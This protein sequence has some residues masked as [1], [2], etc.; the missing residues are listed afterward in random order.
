MFIGEY[1]HSIDNKSR[2]FIPSKFRSGVKK[3]I[4]TRGLE[5]CLFMYPVSSWKNITQKLK[6]LPLAKSEARAFSRILLSGAA[7][8]SIDRQ[9][10]ILVPQNLGSFANVKKNVVIIGVLDRI[11]IWSVENWNSYS[12][13]SIKSF[14]ELAE[15]LIDLGI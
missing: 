15:K 8:C 11:E 14:T 4:L 12:G 10:R 9:G 7:Q 13:K 1:R 3:F 6:S 2:L 5:D